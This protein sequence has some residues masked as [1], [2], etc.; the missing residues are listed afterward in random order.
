MF[1]TS[2][3]ARDALGG[4][5][6]LRRSRR[7]SSVCRLGAVALLS[8]AACATEESK[9][10]EGSKPTPTAKTVPALS[11]TA[12]PAV[13]A[14]TVT[15][16][17][18]RREDWRNLGVTDAFDSALTEKWV[19]AETVSDETACLQ[20]MA[21]KKL[22]RAL[23]VRLTI[24]GGKGWP[25]TLT[26]TAECLIPQANGEV[27]VETD[28]SIKWGYVPPGEKPSGPVAYS[29]RDEAI[30]AKSRVELRRAAAQLAVDLAHQVDAKFEW[31]NPEKV[32]ARL[33]DAEEVPIREPLADARRLHGSGK[34]RDALT[35]VDIAIKAA[36]DRRNVA[37][38]EEAKGLRAQVVDAFI[39]QLLSIARTAEPRQALAAFLDARTIATTER[40]AEVEAARS[41]V[42]D[43]AIQGLARAIETRSGDVAFAIVNDLE[44]VGSEIGEDKVARV[45]HLRKATANELVREAGDLPSTRYQIA[46][47][48]LVKALKMDPGNAQAKALSETVAK[49][50]AELAPTYATGLQAV[51]DGDGLSVEFGVATA[52][53]KLTAADGVADVRIVLTLAG[54][55]A[56]TLYSK[57]YPLT[58][59]NFVRT[60]FLQL[61]ASL[62]RIPY[63]EIGHPFGNPKNGLGGAVMPWGS[64]QLAQQLIESSYEIHLIV[65]FTPSGVDAPL[66]VT[67]ELN[68]LSF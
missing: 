30:I 11:S 34:N 60:T 35:R 41:A 38:G 58:V 36:Q 64:K 37:L 56:K 25:V 21:E 19:K 49:A 26:A 27:R 5:A 12:L 48:L 33:R 8:F 40:R 31:L 2:D 52:T 45:A 47:Q 55:V 67:K 18:S 16:P 14:L 46:G 22:A 44:T 6:M 54:Q 68:P 32:A 39:A 59:E 63:D 66:R 28:R 17:L 13:F 3:F 61:G 20:I 29:D 65:E 1:D 50:R 51:K 42:V 57:K 43:K 23:A 4:D 53:K 24:A 62:P 10:T 7:V 9:P 15:D